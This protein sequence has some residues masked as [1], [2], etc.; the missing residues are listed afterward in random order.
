LNYLTH[1]DRGLIGMGFLLFF[2]ITLLLYAYILYKG[3]WRSRRDARLRNM[4]GFAKL[5]NSI[6]KAV[7][8]GQ[9]L[10]FSTGWGNIAS[11]YSAIAYVEMSILRR[12]TRTISLGDKR[13]VATSGEGSLMLANQGAMRNAYHNA[14]A[15]E[16]YDYLSSQI[17]GLTPF[18]Y[19]SGT[20]IV[21]QDHKPPANV[22]L[23]HFGSEVGLIVNAS[24]DIDSLTLAGSDD[25]T[26]QALL[27]ATANEPLIGEE[28]YAGGAYL[29]AGLMHI[30]SLHAQDFI[31]WL[32]VLIILA[33]VTLKFMGIL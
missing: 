22:L 33:G 5:K 1:I 27:F 31:R 9:K 12:I 23:G 19:A 13:P 8:D 4:P 15:I 6:N 14:E 25:L 16:H 2:L 11:K 28:A 10:H 21:I 18:A 7:E 24:E 29:H 30:A 32:I 26:A 3:D 17:S 20:M